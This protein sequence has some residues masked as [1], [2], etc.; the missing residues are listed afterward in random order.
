MGTIEGLAKLT[1][2]LGSVL[3]GIIGSFR[4][5]VWVLIVLDRRVVILH[6]NLLHVRRMFNGSRS[7]LWNFVNTIVQL[8]QSWQIVVHITIEI[9]VIAVL[10][11]RPF[12]S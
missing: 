9:R 3:K 7:I 1:S 11:E 8:Y 2:A 5:F 12:D 6:F 4:R 10:L